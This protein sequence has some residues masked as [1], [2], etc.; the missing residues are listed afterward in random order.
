MVTLLE[1]LNKVLEYKVLIKALLGY[2]FTCV[3][4]HLVLNQ[5]VLWFGWGDMFFRP[6]LVKILG[7]SMVG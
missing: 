3:V 1:Q 6:D 5:V 7:Q 2:A 4:V